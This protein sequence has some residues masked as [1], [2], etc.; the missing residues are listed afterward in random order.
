MTLLF[1]YQQSEK[2]KDNLLLLLESVRKIGDFD[3]FVMGWKNRAK[4][5]A[6]GHFDGQ[7]KKQS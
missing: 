7:A 2:Q 6:F 1:T 5:P 3:H 4:H